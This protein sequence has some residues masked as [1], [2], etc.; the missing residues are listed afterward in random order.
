MVTN[1]DKIRQKQIV[2]DKVTS[3]WCQ[4]D[5][6]DASGFQLHQRN[7]FGQEAFVANPFGEDLW[8]KSLYLLDFWSWRLLGLETVEFNNKSLKY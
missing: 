3:L 5:V 7:V 1:F 4:R 8:K 2:F 6:M